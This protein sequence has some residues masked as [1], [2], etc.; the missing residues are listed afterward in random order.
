MPIQS[1]RWIPK[2]ATAD[3]RRILATRA[4]RGFGD[5]LVS[6]LLPSYLL[7]LEFSAAQVGVIVFGTLLGSAALTLWVGLASHR[8]GRK[9]VLLAAVALMFATGI[10]FGFA[11]GFWAIFAVAVIGTLNPSAGDVSLF[12][13]VEQAALAQTV[14]SSDLTAAFSLYNVGGAFAGAFGALASGLPSAI[15]PRMGWTLAGAERSGFFVYSA[16][17]VAAAIIYW[18]LTAAIETAPLPATTK[19]LARSRSIVIK[20]SML[21]SLDSFGG[22]FTVQSLLALWLFRRFDLSVAAAGSFFFFAG[23]LGALSQFLSSSIAAR[24]G[25]INTMVFTHLPANV[26]LILAGVMPNLKLAIVFLLLRSLL[27]SMDVPARQSY[28]MAV[29]PPEER[30]AAAGVTNVPRSL[31]S[32]FSPLPAGLMLDYSVFGWPLICAGSIKILYDFLLLRQFR[33]VRPSDEPR[34]V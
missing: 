18:S 25:R 17:A 33:H 19:P 14:V 12:L 6:V 8:I 31:A 9:P 15:A 3:S 24:F 30:A 11:R 16:L 23:L 32:A 26:F 10:G 21:F 34:S 20:L 28:V 2:S 1:G 7:A 13:P 5:G 27:S 29:V 4:L 22:G